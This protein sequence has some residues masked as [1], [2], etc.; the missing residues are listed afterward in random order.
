M[1]TLKELI[2]M[3]IFV[4]GSVLIFS[5]FDQFHWGNFWGGISCFVVAYY[6]WP[7]RKRGYREQE[8]TF[9]DIVELVIELP[10]EIFL[11]IFR[12]SGRIFRGK[13]NDFDIDIDL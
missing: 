9:L 2:A 4:A 7:S 13:N 6:I 5:V 11:W 8:N 3:L 10:V 12:S 1:E